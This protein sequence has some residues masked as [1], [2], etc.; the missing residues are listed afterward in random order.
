MNIYAVN[1]KGRSDSVTVETFTLETALKQTGTRV[2]HLLIILARY[3]R[4]CAPPSAKSRS[5]QQSEISFLI[6][7]RRFERETSTTPRR[8]DWAGSDLFGFRY[9]RFVRATQPHALEFANAL[10][11]RERRAGGESELHIKSR[12]LRGE[13]HSRC[14]TM[15]Q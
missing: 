2:T 11:E 4:N 13:K 12:R 15:Q 5:E 8:S 1:S 14:D 6:R 10:H 3:L 9:G 7:R